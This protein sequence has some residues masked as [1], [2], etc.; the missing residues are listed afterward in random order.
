MTNKNNRY[1][2][3]EDILASIER[4]LPR[5]G[6]RNPMIG[7]GAPNFDWHYPDEYFWTDSFWTGQLW[8]AYSLTGE[9]KFKNSARMRRVQME[10]ILATPMWIDHDMGFL[11]S[12]TAVADYKLT[13]CS[14]AKAQALR[15][16]EALRNRFNWNGRYLPAWNAQPN[17]PGHAEFVQGKIIID[18]MQ[19]LGLLL[20]AHKE[21]CIE[22]F[23]EVALQQAD[24]TL[25]Y[26]VR[27]DFSTY[28]SFNFDPKTNE[29][30][31]GKTVQGFADESCWSRGHSWAVHGFAQLAETTGNLEY[32][33]ISA[34]LADYVIEHITDDYIPL[35]DYSLPTSE[36][37]YKDTSAGAVTASG[38]YI[39]ADVY[40]KAGR[41]EEAAKYHAFAEKMLTALRIHHD[42]TE[43]EHAEGLLSGAASFVKMM[44]GPETSYLADGMLPYGDYYY[45]EAVMRSLGHNQFFWN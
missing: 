8:L 13:G 25:K 12:L 45:F 23:K 38:I 31:E 34:K 18:C 24:T 35:W 2:V 1:Q 17:N 19:N 22:S 11:Y 5:I 10:K 6:T 26:L 3:Q 14:E 28:H 4:N 40:K 43:V 16:A 42:L 32:A 39:L 37:Q 15:A 44:K 30:I 21:T 20:W 41:L 9:E 36:T 7:N 29:P 27:D 33:D